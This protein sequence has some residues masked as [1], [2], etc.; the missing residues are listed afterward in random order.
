MNSFPY[1]HDTDD[2]WGAIEFYDNVGNTTGWFSVGYA[3]NSTLNNKYYCICGYPTYYMT[4]N[5][6]SPIHG[7]NVFMYESSSGLCGL[8]TYRLFFMADTLGGQSG[9]PV[10]VYMDNTVDG[11][12]KGTYYLD[13]VP[14]YNM[15]RRITKSLYDMME[16]NG[17]IN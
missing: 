7:K 3:S 8:S 10:R 5:P 12:Y 15:A 6:S 2:D 4:N 11:I 1:T 16:D 14:Q 17:W 9:C 13:D